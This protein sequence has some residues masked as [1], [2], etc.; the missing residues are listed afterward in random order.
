MDWWKLKL[1]ESIPLNPLLNVWNLNWNWLKYLPL[2][3]RVS[4]AKFLF[5]KFCLFFA[6]LYDWI[7]IKLITEEGTVGIIESA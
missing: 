4:E 1:N 5:G 3:V 6:M 2:T 7:Y